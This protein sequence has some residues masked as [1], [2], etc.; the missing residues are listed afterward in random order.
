MQV[1]QLIF[2]RI[3]NLDPKVA[4]TINES[5]FISEDAEEMPKVAFPKSVQILLNSRQLWLAVEDHCYTPSDL[6]KSFFVR[7]DGKHKDPDL[8]SVFIADRKRYIAENWGIKPN[9]AWN[10]QRHQYW[11]KDFVV[12]LFTYIVDCEESDWKNKNKLEWKIRK[13]FKLKE[14]V[15]EFKQINTRTIQI[16]NKRRPHNP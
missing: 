1:S 3:H 11:D 8:F 5:Y 10:K 12:A 15:E 4:P 9:K 14:M 13:D 16:I 2:R 6:V 7:K